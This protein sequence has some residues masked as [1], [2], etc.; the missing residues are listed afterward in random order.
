MSDRLVPDDAG[1]SV[2][3]DRHVDARLG[4]RG[5][6]TKKSA[7]SAEVG[8]ADE[9]IETVGRQRQNAVP[10]RLSPRRLAAASNEMCFN[11]WSIENDG[12]KLISTFVVDHR[13]NQPF[14]GRAPIIAATLVDA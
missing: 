11:A 14:A 5:T 2:G 10:K 8:K 4:D 9:R 12:Q 1:G 7:I 6:A 3:L 13:E